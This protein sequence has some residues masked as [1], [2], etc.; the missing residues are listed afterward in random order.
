[1]NEPEWFKEITIRYEERESSDSYRAKLLDSFNKPQFNLNYYA[2][3]F[4]NTIKDHKGVKNYYD[5]R[6]RKLL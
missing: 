6:W 4:N 5:R 3:R 1:M 2:R